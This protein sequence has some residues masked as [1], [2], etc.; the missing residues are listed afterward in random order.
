VNFHISTNQLLDHLEAMM[1][2][3]FEP[4][5]NGQEGRFGVSVIRYKQVH[6]DRLGPGDRE[7]LETSDLLPEGK[8]ITKSGW[9][10]K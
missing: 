2:H 1:I 7:L 10:N 4:A 8:K 9:K 6:D 3:A 5:L